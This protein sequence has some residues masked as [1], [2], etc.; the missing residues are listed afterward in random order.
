MRAGPVRRRNIELDPVETYGTTQNP[1]RREPDE[2]VRGEDED[3]ERTT[4]IRAPR[5]PEIP[6]TGTQPIS[7]RLIEG[8]ERPGDFMGRIN[9]GKIRDTRGQS[10]FNLQGDIDP[11]AGHFIPQRIF[12]PNPSKYIQKPDVSYTKTD[13][14]RAPSPV[15]GMP[16]SGQEEETISHMNNQDV[17]QV[18]NVNNGNIRNYTRNSSIN[19]EP[20]PNPS[21]N[22]KQGG[23][24]QKPAVEP[25]EQRTRLTAQPG[26]GA[27]PDDAVRDAGTFRDEEAPPSFSWS[28]PDVGILGAR[29]KP[30]A[31]P[32]RINVANV[33]IQDASQVGTSGAVRKTG[34]GG[35]V[36][37]GIETA[38]EIGG[39][40]DEPGSML[41]KLAQ[42]KVAGAV[43]KALFIAPGADDLYKDISGGKVAGRNIYDKISNVGTIAGTA[44][45]LVPGLDLLGGVADLGA[46]VT[47]EIGDE[48]DKEAQDA[49]VQKEDKTPAQTI[50]QPTQGSVGGAG[51]FVT[52]KA[53][54]NQITSGVGSF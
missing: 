47:G 41:S 24:Y 22:I 26:A 6:D 1:L 31:V 28:D 9:P 54:Q 36:E 19:D 51:G 20:A 23:L 39:K 18:R 42:S 34:L 2:P 5:A 16:R 21:Y 15:R 32:T 25:Q 43:G 4:T 12:A 10:V 13:T 37:S 3:I 53:P 40:L 35:A 38:K 29:P 8:S 44:L 48:K 45:D 11:E 49:E 50:A 7:R 46:M 17:V 14:I 27:P 33:A 52:S 30:G